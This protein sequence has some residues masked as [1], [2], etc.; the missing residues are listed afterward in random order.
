M[1]QR[2]GPDVKSKKSLARYLGRSKKAKKIPGVKWM[3]PKLWRP[4]IGVGVTQRHSEEIKL[5]GTNTF[6]HSVCINLVMSISQDFFNF[7]SRFCDFF[8]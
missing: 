8:R 2:I 3:F 6:D 4:G 1:P 7:W 5:A